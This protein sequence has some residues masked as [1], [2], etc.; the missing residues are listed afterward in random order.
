MANAKLTIIVDAKDQAS[1]KLSGLKGALSGIGG[2]AK[3]ALGVGLGMGLAAIPGM[4]MGAARAIGDFVG[5]AADVEA[6][7]NTFGK[8]AESIGTTSDE[9]LGGLRQATRGMVADADLMQASNKFVAMGIAS[10]ADEAAQMAEVATQLGM[11]MGEDA[12]ASMENFAL[13]MANQSIPRLDSFGISSGKVRERIDELMESTE[14][15]TREQAFNIAVMEEAGVAMAK[16]GEQGEGT[17][18]GMARAKAGFENAKLA[19][20]QAFLPIL[21]KATEAIAGLV[22]KYGPM[23]AEGAAQ[24]GEWISQ[25]IDFIAPL[26]EGLVSEWGPKIQ[27]FF[28][29]VWGAIQ[30]AWAFIEPIFESLFGAFSEKGPEA[31]GVFGGIIEQISGFLQGLLGNALQFARDKFAFVVDWVQANWPL[32]QAT[33]QT[34]ITTIQTVIT[35]V[36]GAI[37]QFWD[38]WGSTILQYVTNV[39]EMIKGVIDTVI[40]AILGI[41]KAIMQIIQGD[42]Q[43]A[44]D[45]IKATAETIWANIK[46][47]IGVAIEN[48]KIV[49]SIALDT[50]KAVWSKAW[51]W[52]KE[53]LG[54][55]IEPIVA[56]VSEW[57]GKIKG[58]FDDISGAVGAV[59]DKISEVL[60]KIAELASKAIPKWLQGKSPPPMANWFNQIAEASR[61]ASLGIEAQARTLGRLNSISGPTVGLAPEAQDGGWG[62]QAGPAQGPI[63]GSVNIYTT[64]MAPAVVHDLAMLRARGA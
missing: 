56:K 33:I 36:L 38:Q 57:A 21:S 11:A 2:I 59:I 39:W 49:I 42:W 17:A 60:R 34:V 50:I 54:P 29:M 5:E 44:W 28:T 16:V 64:G 52:L 45:T 31:M 7:A 9:L 22:E 62:R 1:Q 14:G 41:I 55:F 43:G 18:A 61:A 37:Q 20:G 15:M 26:I 27:E 46:R 30:E 10:T 35:T 13:M 47:I 19:I 23:L 6:V 48:V 3:Q 24:V 4:A 12:T 40:T 25:A 53:K 58:F 32:I 51:G 63:F 8:L